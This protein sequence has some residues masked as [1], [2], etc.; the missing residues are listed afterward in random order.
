MSRPVLCLELEADS[1]PFLWGNGGFPEQT[2]VFW[3]GG[4]GSK[5]PRLVEQL[6]GSWR[7]G[8]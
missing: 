7:Q 4:G 2:D 3:K 8:R 1:T 5:K 6:K